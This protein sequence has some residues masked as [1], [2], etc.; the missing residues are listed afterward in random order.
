M[1]G[2]NKLG[3][4]PAILVPVVLS[5][6]LLPDVGSG[7]AFAAEAEAALDNGPA[8][9]EPIEGTALSRITLSEKAAMRLD[10]QTM[11]VRQEDSGKMTVPY[12]AVVYDTAG[13]TWVYT[14]PKPLVF[15]RH[16]VSI[17][18]IKGDNVLLNDGPAAGTLVV[19]TGVAELYGT[20]QGIGH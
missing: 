2:N 17:D 1:R 14:N 19:M 20:E 8:H 13:A 12:S 4:L 6:W 16:G 3:L 18:K 5:L 15:V 9:V 7:S 11:E 10:I